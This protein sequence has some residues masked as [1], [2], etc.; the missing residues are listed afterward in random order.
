[1]TLLK[2]LVYASNLDHLS[3]G[4]NHIEKIWFMC[5]KLQIRLV[6]TLTFVHTVTQCDKHATGLISLAMI[7]S[8]V[9]SNWNCRQPLL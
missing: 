5:L 8:A 7:T 4:H 1:M 9:M 6:V 2:N 3:V